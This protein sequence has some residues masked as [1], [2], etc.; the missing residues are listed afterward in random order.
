M[1][2]WLSVVVLGRRRI[3]ESVKWFP[4]MPSIIFFL[5]G[6]VEEDL[7]VGEMGLLLERKP[8]AFMLGSDMH[9]GVKR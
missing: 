6:N 5:M 7:K 4:P 1:G 9:S 3:G 8:L 2:N